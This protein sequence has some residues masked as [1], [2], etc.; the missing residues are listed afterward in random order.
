MS[1]DE[2][3]IAVLTNERDEYREQ[4][5]VCFEHHRKLRVERDEYRDKAVAVSEQNLRLMAERDR[6]RETLRFYAS[7]GNR[8][9]RTLDGEA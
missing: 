2:A 4:A 3:R 6:Y 5:I 1:S 9:A 7:P 8:A